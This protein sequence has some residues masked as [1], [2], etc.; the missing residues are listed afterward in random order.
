MSVG[1]Y[2]IA[3][4]GGVTASGYFATNTVK[5]TAALLKHIFVDF[6]E[7]TSNF[8]FKL[9]DN[10]DRN[11]IYLNSCNTVLNRSYDVPIKGIYT[12][13]LSNSTADAPFKIR[14]AAQ[15]V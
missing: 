12:I 10:K 4:T 9:V 14:F 7:T 8:E 5:I 15:D 1:I 6:G 3:D 13:V 2:E 11:I